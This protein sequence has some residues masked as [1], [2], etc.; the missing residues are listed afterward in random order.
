MEKTITIFTDGSSRGNPGPGG[1]AAIITTPEGKV[2]E[3]G[4]REEKTTNNRMELS[5]ALA[6]LR[7]I[8]ERGLSGD[9]RIYT[10]SAYLLNGITGWVYA[11]EKN[12]WKTKTGEPVLNQDI[13]QELSG[14]VFRQKLIRSIEWIKVE[15]HAGLRG[16]ERADEIATTFADQKNMALFSGAKEK[17]EKLLGGSLFDKN[18]AKEEKKKLSRP[19]GK[20]YSYVS[21][22]GGMIATHKTWQECERRVKGKSGAKFKKALSPQEEKQII[23]EWTNPKKDDGHRTI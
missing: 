18:P 23:S 4:G 11:W 6:T 15:G 13:W 16:N 7:Y 22:I 8:E 12:G 19:K 2:V 10:D 9:I 5:A 20:A 17:Y 1:F 14:I 21:M 3:L